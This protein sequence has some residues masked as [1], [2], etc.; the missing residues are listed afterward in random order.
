V[1]AAFCAAVCAHTL[2]LLPPAPYVLLLFLVIA[3]RKGFAFSAVILTLAQ[4]MAAVV[5]LSRFTVRSLAY[6]ASNT[7]TCAALFAEARCRPLLCFLHAL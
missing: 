5:A 4:A 6:Q 1:A 2:Q 3:P 7:L